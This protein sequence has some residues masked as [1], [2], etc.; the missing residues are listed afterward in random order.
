MP[1]RNRRDF[2]QTAPPA[3]THACCAAIRGANSP[4]R[5]H[6][7]RSR[8]ALRARPALI[9][10]MTSDH[11]KHAPTRPRRRR[12]RLRRV[13]HP[14]IGLLRPG[15][16]QK[17]L[18]GCARPASV[19]PSGAESVSPVTAHA[20]SRTQAALRPRGTA[21]EPASGYGPMISCSRALKPPGTC[22]WRAHRA[23]GLILV[24]R[25]CAGCWLQH[26]GLD[27]RADVP[28]FEGGSN[29]VRDPAGHGET[30][31]A[32]GKAPGEAVRN[33]F[34]VPADAPTSC[35][36]ARRSANPTPSRRS[37][38]PGRVPNIIGP[39][40]PSWDVCRAV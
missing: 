23:S 2:D 19:V 5:R 12:G 32:R 13:R 9:R 28:A 1:R 36:I 16:R 15:R 37:G 18:A 10:K 31:V 30:G 7:R 34:R 14:N 38:E 6:L 17:G 39:S 20:A 40:F 33:R 26:L 4:A 24:H 11:T 3:P 29:D 27:R 35:E 25:G 21:P 22:L 8:G